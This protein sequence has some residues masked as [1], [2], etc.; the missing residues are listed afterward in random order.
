MYFRGGCPDHSRPSE[1]ENP[2]GTFALLQ[3]ARSYQDPDAIV[4]LGSQ[5]S[6]LPA[7]G[8]ADRRG[9][10]RVA[11]RDR[12]RDHLLPAPLALP[13]EPHGRMRILSSFRSVGPGQAQIID[14]RRLPKARPNKPSA[15][16]FDLHE[17]TM[18]QAIDL[19]L[20]HDPAH[21][22]RSLVR[23]GWGKN[24]RPSGGHCGC[25]HQCFWYVVLRSR[26]PLFSGHWQRCRSGSA[27]L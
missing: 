4:S 8:P 1:S 20:G 11:L 26:S 13:R 7:R 22:E 24:V 25:S 19:W 15:G 17:T 5:G 27:I 12:V 18:T 14:R 16:R 3:S 23:I 9:R 2:H 10:L 6:P 21:R